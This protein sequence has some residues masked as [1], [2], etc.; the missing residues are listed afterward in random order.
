MV[1]LV[2]PGSQVSL[3]LLPPDCQIPVVVRLGTSD[4]QQ[5]HDR[6]REAG[7]ALHNED[8]VRMEGGR[9]NTVLGANLAITSI[10]SHSSRGTWRYNLRLTDGFYIQQ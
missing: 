10:D 3:L 6:I 2:P 7:V 9:D 1:E 4:A 8:L 5:A